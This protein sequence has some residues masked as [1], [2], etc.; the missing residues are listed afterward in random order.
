MPD[1][2]A[3]GEHDLERNDVIGGHP[4]FEAVRSAG[5]LGDVAAYRAG[6]LAG[7]VRHILEAERR[8]G[9]G[10]PG[11]HDTGLNHCPPLNR[12]YPENAVHSSEGDE[13]RIRLGKRSARKP[14][15][16]A[17]GNERHLNQMQKAHDF[18]HLGG[19]SRHDH[20]ARNRFVGGETIH[21]VSHQ[22]GAPVAHP[23]G[24]NDPGQGIE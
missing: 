12:V 22:L 20:H 7:R 19:V 15:A 21:G 18:P 6:R 4:V 17:P 3:V 24:S 10:K 2:R 8:H 5:V 1:D 14:G 23:L 13:H 11:I 16:S 9:F